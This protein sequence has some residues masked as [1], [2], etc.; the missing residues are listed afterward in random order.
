MQPPLMPAAQQHGLS[1]AAIPVFPVYGN[2]DYPVQP[3]YVDELAAQAVEAGS[4]SENSP[5]AYAPCLAT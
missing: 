1:T 3:V 5:T 4:Q 2:G